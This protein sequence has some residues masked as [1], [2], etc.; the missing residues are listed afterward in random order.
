MAKL[1]YSALTSLAGYVADVSATAWC[2]CTT[3]PR[4]EALG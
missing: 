3:A 4:R 2:T 1:I